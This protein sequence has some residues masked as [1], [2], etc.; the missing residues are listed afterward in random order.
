MSGFREVDADLISAAGF[1]SD[2][3]SGDGRAA[4]RYRELGQ[5][6]PVGD[7]NFALICVS[8]GVA[9][10]IFAGGEVAADGA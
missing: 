6:F 3:E 2:L 1:K 10:E 7:G 5:K 9:A 4:S 8:G